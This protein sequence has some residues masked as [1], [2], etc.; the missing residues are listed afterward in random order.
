M[1]P[2]VLVSITILL[3]FYFL[4]R[5]TKKAVLNILNRLFDKVEINNLFGTLSYLLVLGLGLV[6]A[7]NV[8]H[9]EQTVSSL[10]AGAGI[11][12]LA[13]GFAFQDIT[14]NFISGVLIAFKEPIQVGDVVDIKNYTG[15]VEEISLRTTVI[16]TFQGLHVI[17][18]N[19][20]VYQSAITNFT[21]THDRR[22]DIEIGVSYSED[23][24]NVQKIAVEAVSALP[25]LLPHKEVKALFQ[26]F[27]ESSI[28]FKLLLWISYPGEPGYLQAR[29]DA[30]VAIKQA[31]DENNI[32]IPFP[33]RT[34]DFSSSEQE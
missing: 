34:L 4:A 27:G 26:A 6:M 22:I 15:V 30:I 18:P 19:K 2:N 16:R 23:L 21:K 13:L 20:E 12:G 25:Y 17:I 29:S 14:T 32:T 8:M 5:L 7:L 10:L 31:F 24:Q 28:N 9:L 33:I 1:L 3:G 11:I